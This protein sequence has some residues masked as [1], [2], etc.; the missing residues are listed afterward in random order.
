MK[1]LL[2]PL[3]ILAIIISLP[4]CFT[5]DEYFVGMRPD[6]TGIE[7]EV[8]LIN[9]HYE[10]QTK[11]FYKNF[12][13]EL[14]LSKDDILKYEHV[15]VKAD[16]SVYIIG[17]KQTVSGVGSGKFQF[18]TDGNFSNL[19]TITDLPSFDENLRENYFTG[20][21]DDYF[22]FSGSSIFRNGDSIGTVQ[23]NSQKYQPAWQL[24]AND[25]IYNFLTKDSWD[26]SGIIG[27]NLIRSTPPVYR[28]SLPGSFIRSSGFMIGNIPYFMGVKGSTGFEIYRGDY[29]D[30]YRNA[31]EVGYR[32]MLF[33]TVTNVNAFGHVYYNVVDG[34]VAYTLALEYNKFRLVKY[35]AQT[36]TVT[37]EANFTAEYTEQNAQN[38]VKLLKSGVAFLMVTDGNGYR[39]DDTHEYELFKVSAA[40]SK[41]YGIIDTR[42]FDS[43]IA[44]HY[45]GFYIINNEPVIWFSSGGGQTYSD[46]LLVVTPK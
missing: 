31:N 19:S 16:G 20:P 25:N 29:V 30:L 5:S 26:G 42:D 21:S 36:S 35:D 46:H 27:V 18:Q 38:T 43:K 22:F 45:E 12:Q 41:S 33:Q 39:E 2:F 23:V 34:Q 24:D 9:D 8:A 40:E 1:G 13:E 6:S 3:T 11:V 17:S 14:G 7:R 37:Q 28:W 4:S 10:I 32:V 44:L 15:K